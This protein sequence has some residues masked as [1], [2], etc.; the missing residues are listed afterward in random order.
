MDDLDITVF[1]PARNEEDNIAL[2]VG[3]IIA[4]FAAHP[5][6][7][8]EIVLVDDGSTDRTLER[9]KDLASD[10]SCSIVDCEIF[11]SD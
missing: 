1:V 7:S 10:S 9:M 4:A 11:R 8:Y 2:V 6:L 5:H 3:D